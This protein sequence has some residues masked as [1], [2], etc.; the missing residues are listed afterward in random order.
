MSNLEGAAYDLGVVTIDLL[1]KGGDLLALDPQA[2]AAAKQAFSDFGKLLI[3]E[4]IRAV[5]Q[6]PEP[7]SFFNFCGN[8]FLTTHCVNSNNTS[9]YREKIKQFQ[10]G[11]Y[12]IKFVSGFDLP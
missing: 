12:F 6:S 7:A 4:Q 3:K 1:N 11:C 2:F 10:N 5:S 8:V 9:L